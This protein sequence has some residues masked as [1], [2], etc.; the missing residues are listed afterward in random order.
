MIKAAVDEDKV[1][2]VQANRY[3]GYMVW[4]NA[5]VASAGGEIITNVEEGK[6]ATPDDRLPGRR[7]GREGRR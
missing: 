1:I 6:N 5:L 3:E 4:I 2:G 7:R